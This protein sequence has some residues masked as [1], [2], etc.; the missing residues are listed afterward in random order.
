MAS[1]LQNLYNII[2]AEL[3]QS[4]I[5]NIETDT[6]S[7]GK[8]ISANWEH[9]AREVCQEF[10]F[11]SVR[12]DI[13]LSAVSSSDELPPPY[14][15]KYALPSDYIDLIAINHKTILEPNARALQ[16]YWGE[17]KV[18]ID[19]TTQSRFL[20][21]DYE[22]KW[23]SYKRVP[24]IDMMEPLLVSTIALRTAARISKS[25]T[26]SESKS[27][28]IEQK[29]IEKMAAAIGSGIAAQSSDIIDGSYWLDAMR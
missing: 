22:V 7:I 8:N 18:I 27:Q 6:S 28:A 14:T 17:H 25:I 13:K 3:S 5:N 15:L 4:P 9:V 10:A 23:V 24:H 11:A 21:T 12:K 26:E 16:G 29:A 1:N 19:D 20:L 2:C